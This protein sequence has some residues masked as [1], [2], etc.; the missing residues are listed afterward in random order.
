MKF[1]CVKNS[2]VRLIIEL[3]IYL[4]FQLNRNH[5]NLINCDLV[6]FLEQKS[7]TNCVTF[8]IRVWGGIRESNP[9]MAGSQPVVLNRFTN[10]ASG[11]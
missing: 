6:P 5:T 4:L 10:S 1:V 3:R 8:V 9:C 7:G 2:H 11:Y